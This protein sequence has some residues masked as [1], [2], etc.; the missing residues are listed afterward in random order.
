M[1]RKVPGAKPEVSQQV[2]ALAKTFGLAANCLVDVAS[3]KGELPGNIAGALDVS[4]ILQ[5]IP[6]FSAEVGTG[7]IFEEENID[8]AETGSGT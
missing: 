3:A 8:I 6:A 7:G 4:C 1:C 2:E 5:G